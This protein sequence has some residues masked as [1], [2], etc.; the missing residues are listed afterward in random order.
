MS[1]NCTVNDTL[2][3]HELCKD[4]QY[5]WQVHMKGSKNRNQ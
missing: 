5:T 1:G 2:L 4:N 3:L